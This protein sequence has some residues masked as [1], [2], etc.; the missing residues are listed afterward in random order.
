VPFRRIDIHSHLNF[1]AYDADRDAVARRALDSGTAFINVGTQADTSL[2][3]VKL[4]HAYEK[5]VYAI[6][7]LHPVHTDASF[8]DQEELG[9]GGKEF[10]SRGE[11]FDPV[12]Y[13]EL[14][15]DPKVVGIGEC[16]LDYYHHDPA[17]AEKQKAA[18]ISEIELADESKKPLMLHIRNAYIDALEILKSYPRV[19]GDVH[20][21]AGTIDEARQFLDLGYTLSFT[22]VVTFA[23]Q[24]AELIEYVPLDMIQA[25]TDCPFVAPVPH[26]GQRNEPSYVSEVYEKI[27][28][29]K[30][31]PLEEVERALLDNA[32]RVFGIDLQ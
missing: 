14:L 10:T 27:A 8:H 31:L 9:E 16:G 32:R 18:F 20:F 19:K 21:F 1:A 3:A 11:S 29:I 7:G 17:Q 4:A 13:R 12:V 5:G 6:V 25:E 24:Y 28:Q 15:K 30:K 22:G 23:K 2:A 26:R